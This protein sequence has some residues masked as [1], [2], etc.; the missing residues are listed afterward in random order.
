MGFHVYA[1]LPHLTE[2]EVFEGFQ[3]TADESGDGYGVFLNGKLCREFDDRS[4]AD[5]FES[6]VRDAIQN[7]LDG[8]VTITVIIDDL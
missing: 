5:A 8:G 7:A 4:D 3:V 1:K 2:F 6:V